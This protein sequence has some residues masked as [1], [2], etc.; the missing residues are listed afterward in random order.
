MNTKSLVCLVAILE[1]VLPQLYKTWHWRQ[2]HLK[3]FDLSTALQKNNTDFY[4]WL[5][6]EPA[7]TTAEISKDHHQLVFK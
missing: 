3:L 1:M 2:D 7:A 5:G 6:V 4:A